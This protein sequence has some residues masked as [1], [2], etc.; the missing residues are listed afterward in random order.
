MRWTLFL[1][2]ILLCYGTAHAHRVNV[3]A[4][5][6]AGRVYVEGYFVDGTKAK[7]STVE[8]LRADTGE[9]L[10]TGRTDNEGRFS[11]KIPGPYPLKIILQASMGHQNEYLL[12]KPEV[13]EALGMEVEEAESTT[14]QEHEGAVHGTE[15]LETMLQRHLEPLREEL[16]RLRMAQERPSLR[17]ILGGLGYIIGLAGIYLYMKSKRN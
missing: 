4:Y 2:V 8:V 5:A 14:V 16:L 6:E 15:D 17:D 10:L 13:L 3:Y 9:K 12:D 1:I 11:F 7:N